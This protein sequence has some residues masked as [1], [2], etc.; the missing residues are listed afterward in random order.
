M[1][2]QQV[3]DFGFDKPVF[4]MHPDIVIVAHLGKVIFAGQIDNAGDNAEA[5]MQ[6]K[7]HRKR[8]CII[9]L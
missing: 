6:V 5:V 8:N 3:F 4:S 9:N 1:G 7:L 2:L